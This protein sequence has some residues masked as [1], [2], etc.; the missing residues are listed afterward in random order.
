MTVLPIDPYVPQILDAL[1][2]RRAAVV[3]ALPGA[4][5]TTRVP[6][7]LAADGP[8]IVLQP[9]RVAA[10]S[11]AHRV[12]FEQGWT[13][14][15]E[16]GWHVRFEPRFAADTRVLFATEGILTARFQQDPL[17]TGFQTIVLDEFHERSI[18]ADLGLALARQAW[19]ARD[20]LRI[21][22]MSATLDTSH[23]AA[24]LDGCPV[25][26]VPGRLYPVAIGYRPGLSVAAAASELAAETRGSILCFLPG[27]PEITRALP[28][29]RAAIAPD[30][31]VLPLHGSLPSD[32]QDRAVAEAPGR[33]VILATN[34]AE[35]SLTV[36][37]V[38]AVI[39]TGLQKTARYDADR[40]IDSLELGRVSAQS[41]DQRAGRAG[42]LA[43]GVV[44]RLWNE[45]DRL[46]PETE[47]EVHRVDLSDAVLE[48]LAWGG[49]PRRFEWFEPPAADRIDAALTLLEQ[50]G[51]VANGRITELGGRLKRLPLHPRLAR[52]L[53]D[54]G[55][56]EDV[57]RA[58][59]LLSERHILPAHPATTDSDLLAAAGDERSLPRHVGDVARR[60]A[61]AAASAE[62]DHAAQESDEHR[63]LLRA[64]L[65]GYPDRVARRRVPGTPRFLLASGHG[66]VLGRESGVRNADFIVAVDVQAGRA[67]E[68]SEATI[69]IASAIEPEWLPRSLRT[70]RTDHE[71][72]RLGRVRAIRRE[73]YGEIVLA[74][75]P[76]PVDP[77]EAAPLLCDAYARRGLNARDTNLIR[78]LRFAGLAADPVSLIAHAAAGRRSIEE[79]DLTAALDPKS[80]ADLQRLAPDRLAVPSG[81]TAPLR[82][83]EDGSVTASVK[84]QEVFGL[85]DT[86]RLGPRRV[87]VTFELLAPNGRPVQTT[88][89]LRSFWNST[90]P[91][92]RKELRGRYPKHPWP[93]DPWTAMPTARA[94]HRGR[95]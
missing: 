91:E 60:L 59:A 16:V 95:T 89:D 32:E 27:A 62:L 17:I 41:A 76:A 80:A 44:R 31:D 14:G 58:C 12:A 90:Y 57:A 9:R 45:T 88:K 28:E 78:R 70:T 46:R 72:D 25:I 8:V 54:S 65:A 94:R 63:G 53:V 1:R 11:M 33:R 79:I 34:V 73:R 37:G 67:G 24:F 50:L 15:R 48:I 68:G 86:P 83:E 92:V 30:V 2:G 38:T 47:A 5:K 36:P 84:L 56:R 87:A 85:A 71:L 35:T 6:P 13:A 64:V 19:R 75:W 29:V 52:M 42:R 23:V 4:G 20:D 7:A 81:R 61:A 77:A 40:G 49:N 51:A 55:G 18:H 93:E 21:V 43:P 26:E 39:D 74:E 22:V 82:Y 66:A 10:R 69:R 3:S